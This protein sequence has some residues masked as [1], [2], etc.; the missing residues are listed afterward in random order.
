MLDLL[1]IFLGDR[2]LGR[3][4]QPRN[5]FASESLVVNL[6]ER[7]LRAMLAEARMATLAGLLNS[8]GQS[9]WTPRSLTSPRPNLRSTK[10]TDRSRK[11][12]QLVR[13][14]DSRPT[15]SMR[16]RAY[17]VAGTSARP[18]L[19]QRARRTHCDQAFV[20]AQTVGDQ[21]DAVWGQ[22][23]VSLDLDGSDVDD[24]LGRLIELDDGS[25][26][27]RGSSGDRLLPGRSSQ[28]GPFGGCAPLELR[29]ARRRSNPALAIVVPNVS[30]SP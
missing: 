29:R 15:A 7:G 5:H 14:G 22:L 25:A 28:D 9:D 17:Y 8:R 26:R 4:V 27:Q 13:H 2:G 16:S 1:A 10:A 11:T 3:R 20:S 12:S 30:P 23:D 6:L 19:P 18:G 21:R 24:L